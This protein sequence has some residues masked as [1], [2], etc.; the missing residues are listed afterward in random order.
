MPT[1]PAIGYAAKH[2]FSRLKPFRFERES[3]GPGQM[4][5][6]VLFCGICD[7]DIHQT[8]NNWGNTVYPCTPGHEMSG[9][10]RAVG[11]GVTRH[12]VGDLVGIGCMVDGCRT[13]DSCR[14]GEE[15]YCEGPNSFLQTYNGPVSRPNRQ[16]TAR[17]C[18][19]TTIPLGVTRT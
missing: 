5:F 3:A 15:N 14:A 2:S 12:A 16:S 19:G 1:I 18:L 8:K 13:C 4:E 6:E 9:R 10:V 11:P 7:T 17:T